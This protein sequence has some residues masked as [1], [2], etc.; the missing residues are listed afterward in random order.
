VA[1]T[2]METTP[3]TPPTPRRSDAATGPR[4]ASS[5]SADAALSP[6]SSSSSPWQSLPSLLALSVAW[7]GAFVLGRHLAAVQAV[8]GVVAVVSL[9]ILLRPA[10]AR[11]QWF[12]GAGR[13]RLADALV[14][15]VLGLASVVVTHLAFAPL[16]AVAPSLPAEVGQLYTLASVTGPTWPVTVAVVLAE[17]VVWRGAFVAALSASVA[18]P[19]GRAVVGA[20]V[21]GAAQAGGGSAWLVLAAGGLGLF[22]G[23]LAAVRGG[24]LVAPFVA[25][26]VWTL[27]VLGAWPLPGQP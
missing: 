21:Y 23:A 14:G 5:S 2:L 12:G 16:A 6:S 4:A 27:G 10:V 26:A 15:L 22:W 25:H 7:S 17:E 19:V 1:V 8:L 13:V 20:V 9:F 18:S 24:R 3:P 11:R